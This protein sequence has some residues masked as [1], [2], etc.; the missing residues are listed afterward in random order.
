MFAE[1]LDLETIRLRNDQLEV[2]ILPEVGAKLL[3]LIHRPT[4]HNFLWQNSRIRPQR[5]PIEA[6]FDNYWCGGWDDGFPTCEACTHN[7]E[8]YPNLGELRSV[9]WSVDACITESEEPWAKLTAFGP[10]SPIKAEKTIRLRQNSVE[11]EF[12][13]ENISH[14]PI[15]FIWGTHPAYAIEPGCVLHIPARTGLVSQANRPSL[16]EPGQK[17]DWPLVTSAEGSLDM[18]RVLTPGEFAAGHY[19]TDL[20][21]GWYAIE[22]PHKKLGLL[23]EFPLEVCPYLWLWLSYGGWRGYYLA[24]IEPWT[25]CPVTLSE[26]VAAKTHLVLKPGAEFAC[27]V[28]STPWQPPA[29]LDDMLRER[30]LNRD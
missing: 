1:T 23:F 5:Y 29:T 11:M 8:L 22:Y 9:S 27:T 16:G 6:N 20:V 21:A 26:A 15:D 7:G 28:R 10:I 2:S 18:S 12:R 3:D 4:G 25:S 30:G 13:V 24:A 14:L 17:Y 19:A